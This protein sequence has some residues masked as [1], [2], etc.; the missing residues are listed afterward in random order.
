MK[1]TERKL[2]KFI[3]DIRREIDFKDQESF[4]KYKSK[5]KM[6]SSTKVNIGGKETTVKK[7]LGDKIPDKKTKKFDKPQFK[8]VTSK[9]L[10]SHINDIDKVD[11]DVNDGFDTISV[12]S[13]AL[14][15]DKE[16]WE[17]LA[18]ELRD[19]L[20]KSSSIKFAITVDNDGI[21]LDKAS[22]KEEYDNIDYQGDYEEED[23]WDEDGEY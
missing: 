11:I 17:D 4:K 7:A 6:R 13:P 18:L 22:S 21:M 8:K 9:V 1:L 20:E 10:R 2:R 14:Y 12:Y 3:K 23:E 16:N 19:S 15:Y 5:H